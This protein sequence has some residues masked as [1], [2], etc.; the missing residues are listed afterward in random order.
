MFTAETAIL[1]HFQ[2]VGV[3]LLILLGVVIPLLAIPAG[4]RDSYAH[5]FAPQF[6]R[7]KIKTLCR[8]RAVYHTGQYLVKGYCKLFSP[9]RVQVQ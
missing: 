8:Q 1:V 5:G 7:T 2:T 6:L 9:P 4:Q 3:V